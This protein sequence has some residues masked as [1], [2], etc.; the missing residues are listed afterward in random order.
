MARILLVDDE[1][2]VVFLTRRLLESEGHLVL[3]ARGCSDCMRFLKAGTPDLLLMDVMVGCGKN[4]VGGRGGSRCESAEG[5]QVVMFTLENGDGCG[6]EDREWIDPRVER[7]FKIDK[8]FNDLR[9]LL[10]KCESGSRCLNRSLTSLTGF[11]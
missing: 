7:L 8:L 1:W 2:D 9:S 6:T 5:V 11:D 3:E 4:G 10:R